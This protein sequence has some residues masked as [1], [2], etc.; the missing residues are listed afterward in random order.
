MKKS[1]TN[2]DTTSNQKCNGKVIKLVKNDRHLLK[3][4]LGLLVSGLMLHMAATAPVNAAVNPIQSPEQAKQQ[5]LDSLRVAVRQDGGVPLPENLDQFLKSRKA[6]LQLGKALFWDMQI[7]SDGVQA[8][9]SCHFHAGADSRSVNQLNPNRSSIA[10]QRQGD[11]I[12]Y[13]L[14]PLIPDTGFEV[15]QPNGQLTR[16][17]FPFVKTIQDLDIKD[18]GAVRPGLN[19]SNDVSSSMGVFFSLFN[20]V[21][22]GVPKDLGSLLFDPV[23]NLDGKTTVR[24]VEPR[25]APSVINAVFN[26]TNFWEGRA[27]PKFNGQSGFGDQDPTASI[28]INIPGQGINFVTISLGMGSLASQAVSPLAS[29]F[30]MSYG[31][32]S[33]NNSR[34][35]E[36]IG[37]K[38]LGVSASTG[39]SAIPLAQQK[40]HPHDSLLRELTRPPFRGLATTYADLVKAAFQNQ[41]WDTD[42]P[43]EIGTSTY[44]LMESNFS[45]FFG[46]SVALY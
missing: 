30:E 4:P 15:K 32:F 18:T 37:K 34:R 28:G 6:A 43:V 11:V 5:G 10:D 20:G 45:L 21:Q 19:N 3:L 22:P 41:Y 8:C 27:N 44:S 7:G 13:Y 33:Q 26:Y 40:I 2:S 36:D 25:N 17:D 24:R 42:E 12:G 29:P 38:I 16:K 46:L 9:A 35:L 31:D 39:L 1:R 23:W 14:A